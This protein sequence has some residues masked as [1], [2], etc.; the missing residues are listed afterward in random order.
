M[1]R[2][3]GRTITI[4]DVS[5][6]LGEA[7]PRAMVPTNII[8][9]FRAAGIWPINPNIFTES[10]FMTRLVTDRPPPSQLEEPTQ[11]SVIAS[12]CP[13]PSPLEEPVQSSSVSERASPSLLGGSVPM[14][15]SPQDIMP[16]P[17]AGPR[18]QS[19]RERKRRRTR[20]L[21]DT[22]EKAAIEE[23]SNKKL[24]K[25]AEIE[26]KRKIKENRPTKKTVRQIFSLKKIDDD[27]SSDSDECPP[28][29]SS[30]GGEEELCSDGEGHRAFEPIRKEVGEFVVAIYNGL[31]Y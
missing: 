12:D 29:P 7:F 11:R 19:S 15:F 28:L 1:L 20:I 26:M 23:Q 24:A 25:I 27:T 10:E 4:Y 14:H 8:S 18:S 16:Y 22:P 5:E 2:H 9:G 13:L 21:T 30:S 3:P 6:L 31:S 17:K